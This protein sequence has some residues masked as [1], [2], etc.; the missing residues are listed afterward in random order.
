MFH[1]RTL[2]L[3][4][5]FLAGLAA[6]GGS[7]LLAT[8][9]AEAQEPAACLSPN[10]S[11]WPAPA[12]PYFMVVVDTSGSM[13][14]CTA[15]LSN[16]PETCPTTGV[17]NNSCGLYPSR[18]NDA[19]CAMRQTIQAFSGQVNFGLA[20]FAPQISACGG[21]ACV[22]DCVRSRPGDCQPAGIGS[23]TSGCDCPLYA[24]GLYGEN[25]GCNYTNT[26]NTC[27]VFPACSTGAGPGAPN[28]AE[29]VWRNG[30]RILVP[31][32]QDSPTAPDN[33]NTLLDWFDGQCAGD[34]ELFAMGATPLAGS[35]Q[36]AA[37]YL[38][39]G[40]SDWSTSNYCPNGLS[41]THPTP[42]SAS[43]P[44]CRSVNIILV[45]DGDE[46]CDAADAPATVAA[47]LFNN[48]VT[49][50]TRNWKV[51]THVIN[52][53]GGSVAATN[54]IA[55]A[56]GTTTS[57]QAQNEVQLAQALAG[58]VAGAVQ[59]ETCD[60]ADN[61]CNGCTDE[62]YNHYCNTAQTCCAWSTPAQRTACLTGY[63]ASITASDPDGNLELLPC[64]TTGQQAQPQNWLCFD[65][66]DQ[67]DDLDNNCAF[68]VDEGSTKCGSPLACPSA[69]ICDGQ[70]NDCDGLSDEGGVC[71]T[72]VPSP[73]VCDGC[74][75][76]CDGTIDEGA[77]SA[78][79]G[80]ASPANCAG[81]LVCNPPQAAAFPGACVAGGGYQACNNSPQ[82]EICDGIDNNCNGVADDGIAPTACVPAGTPGGLVYG[83]T[84]QCQQGLQA[85]GSNQCIG[86]V[87]PS[88]EVCDGIDNDCDGQID[89]GSFG[90]GQSCGNNQAPCT[91]GTTACVNGALVCQ[92]GTQ[93]QPE[94]CDGIDNNCN[95]SV[96]EAPLV[97]APPPGANGC[98]QLPPTGCAPAD[99]CSFGSLQWCRPPGG[100]CTGV[101]ALTAPCSA[102]SLA[103]G[104]AAGWICQGGKLPEPEV[105]D[106]I[107]NDCSGMADN[108]SLPGVGGVCG[109]DVGECQPGNTICINGGLLCD[110]GQGP[111][112]EVCDG[113]D[114][115]CDG[116]N[117]NGLA[118][119]GACEMPYDT[120]LYPNSNASLS[121]C[122]TGFLQC[123]GS[124]NIVCVGGIGPQPELCDGIDN[125][126]DGLVDEVGP[127]P[128]GI[129]GTANPFP[130]PAANLGE[131]CGI[132]TGAC[133]A[134]QW[135]CINGQ[136]GCAGSQGPIPESC[137]CEDNDCNGVTDN[138][139]P[140]NSPPLCSAGKSCVKSSS[141]CQCASPC[142]G[143]E[144]PC[145]TG[146]ICELVTN[147][148]TGTTLGQ[149]CVVDNCGD[150]STKTVTDGQGNVVCAPGNQQT[151]SCTA[152]PEC[153]CKGQS[154]CQAPCFGVTCSSPLVC[155]NT[156][157]NAG[158][159]VQDTCFNF[160]CGNCTEVCNDNGG[161]VDN[162]CKSD[163]C[164]SG[165]VCEPSANFTTFVCKPSC[166]NVDCPDTATCV[167][168][169]CK[170]KCSPD[171]PS[172]EYCDYTQDPPACA[173][174]QCADEFCPN[175]ACCDPATGQ[176]GA[177][178]CEGVLCPDQ[179]VC[180]DGECIDTTGEGG[181]G[182]GGGAT[183]GT[184]TTT[185]AGGGGTTTGTGANTGAGGEDVEQG[186]WGLAT[187]GGGCSCEV[188]GASSDRSAPSLA[189][190]FFAALGAR[191]K[192][193][194]EEAKATDAEASTKEVL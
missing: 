155:T 69:E 131:S 70:D 191:R 64:T 41:F 193:K 20:T 55:A 107:D 183:T 39:A 182:Q 4:P 114:N 24:T 2:S 47:D 151:P 83:G 122:Q 143:G 166:A 1:R 7:A 16:F 140:N 76:D 192:R 42:L 10:P 194:L 49:I 102:G 153:V 30:G 121:P 3:A 28:Y 152:I 178:P 128:N 134:G 68:G 62:G 148:E 15:P 52:F 174:N 111:V 46:S 13:V 22:E 63:Q 88:A 51:R 80:L 96:D 17:T 138:Q 101:G 12:K 93:P 27:G 190:A 173:T 165:E 61:N 23:G 147:S 119:G 72:C 75:N 144:F 112:P 50:G 189:L 35:L 186:V 164:P 113:L 177:C 188:Q 36:S 25:Y 21:G 184:G 65:P 118:I 71:G 185:G 176:C 130:P 170:P 89:E 127:A 175:G 125:D 171:C 129:N 141:G 103:C 160:G 34:R 161:C 109:T 14:Q 53:A 98:W 18:L 100:T 180:Q 29:G 54:A 79:C 108:G 115:D 57:L 85:C 99:L 37:Q 187:G 56:G 162:P 133:T 159:C 126:C 104:G 31:I 149:F 156:G 136:F 74:D 9:P 169:E 32:K 163:S 137:D 67:C 59:P 84:S 123:D 95:G 91:P 158:Q 66:G 6:F 77:P 92:G 139:N 105:C 110:G 81:T 60:N 8:A 106:G 19:K 117:D 145:P 86:F 26:A 132:D 181:G 157:P 11:D 58:I 90:V 167:A 73:E 5:F 146:Q 116:T 179:Q 168:G 33:T 142:A 135:A 97:G 124:G 43:D 172:G 150:C 87:G 38:R 94:I 40:W 120:A 78:P 44:P 45:T 154:G 82:P 48:G